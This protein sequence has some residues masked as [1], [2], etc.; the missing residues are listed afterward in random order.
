MT[1][2]SGIHLLFVAIMSL[3]AGRF[4]TD[5]TTLLRRLHIPS[6][7]TGGLLFCILL[8]T[9]SYLTTVHFNYDLHLR[10][11]LLLVF[12]STIGL[13][14]KIRLLISGGKTLIILIF[15]TIAFLIIQNTAGILTAMA[16]GQDPIFG[17]LAGTIT[18]AGGH[19][20]AI[21]WGAFLEQQGYQGAVEFGLV[22]ATVGLIL[23]G[24]IGG[25]VG[26]KLITHYRLKEATKQKITSSYQ[27]PEIQVVPLNGKHLLSALFLISCCIVFGQLAQD[28]LKAQNILFPDFVPVLFVGILIANLCDFGQEKLRQPE[29]DMLGDVCLRLFIAMSLITLKLH[30]LTNIAG[31]L[32]C[33]TV[34]QVLIIIAF[35]WLVV[36]RAT[37]RNYDSSIIS[38]GFIGM[39]LGAT[40]VGMANMNTLTNRYGLSP[41]A[42]LIVPLIGSFFVDIANA[43][44]LKGFL[45]LPIFKG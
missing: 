42:F 32:V 25:P 44:I 9:Y 15:V 1:N 18:F 40:P 21:T 10:D 3:F 2:I 13:S 26:K 11:I 4:I 27:E 33:I 34:V 37:G 24:L 19:G 8:T 17:L 43:I 7:V 29:L 39:G 28:L 23:G 30:H 20:T 36:F 35:A 31:V 22:A 14:A 6:P 5:N 45:E 38:A 12:F 41:K 16:L